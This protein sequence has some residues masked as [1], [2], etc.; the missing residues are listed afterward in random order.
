MTL[1]GSG[2]V[3]KACVL[4]LDYGDVNHKLMTEDMGMRLRI[5]KS[6][7]TDDIILEDPLAILL[8]I[9]KI[10]NCLPH[11]HFEVCRVI[12]VLQT[13]A[14]QIASDFAREFRQESSWALGYSHPS[15]ID[16]YIVSNMAEEDMHGDNDVKDYIFDLY[17]YLDTPYPVYYNSDDDGN[18]AY[19]TIFEENDDEMQNIDNKKNK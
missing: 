3:Y 8:Y 5:S 17:F 6:N 12:Q 11:D 19:D 16:F 9:S 10:S 14:L 7:N 1:Y 18:E 2:T 13:M 4:M 15:V